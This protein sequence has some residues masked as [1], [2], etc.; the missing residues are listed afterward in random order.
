MIYE[1]H[2][3]G[4]TMRH[5]GIPPELRGIY[6]GLNAIRAA[7][8]YESGAPA[9]AARLEF[10]A[11][12]RTASSLAT[13]G[14]RAEVFSSQPRRRTTAPLAA[15]LVVATVTGRDHRCRRRR[16]T[17]GSRHAPGTPVTT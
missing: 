12:H 11:V 6:A 10:A 9:P 2:V 5:P 1:M 13:A 17:F 3:K 15:L 7:L 14:W 8:I 16:G 4:F